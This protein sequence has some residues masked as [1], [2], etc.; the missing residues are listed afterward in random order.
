ME[1]KF[2][3]QGSIVVADGEK[4]VEKNKTTIAEIA[5]MLNI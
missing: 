4:D 3:A 2:P 5:A 1:F